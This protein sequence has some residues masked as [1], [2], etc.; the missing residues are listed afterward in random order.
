M[1]SSILVLGFITA[2][3]IFLLKSSTC[4]NANSLEAGSFQD[5]SPVTTSNTKFR[6]RRYV[7]NSIEE[8]ADPNSPTVENANATSST[9]VVAT[10]STNKKKSGST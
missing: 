6:R 4:V 2:F 1:R 8:R 5:S 10:Q 9:S 3:I 7:V